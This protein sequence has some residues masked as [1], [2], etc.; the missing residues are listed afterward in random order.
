MLP[1]CTERHVIYP[2]P[3]SYPDP[4]K[5]CYKFLQHSVTSDSAYY[6]HSSG[7]NV[8]GGSL[9]R[10]KK[11]K[12]KEGNQLDSLMLASQPRY[13]INEYYCTKPNRRQI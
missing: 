1:L 8:V 5:Y 12:K 9:Q 2:D 10:S 11:L 3:M 7:S 13:V 6:S 4:D